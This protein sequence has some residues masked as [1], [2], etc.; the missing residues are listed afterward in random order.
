MLFFRSKEKIATWYEKHRLPRGAILS[1]G[2]TWALAKAW[3]HNRMDPDYR[4][5][6]AE[7]AQA[8]FRQVGL[9]S[10]FWS[11]AGG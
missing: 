10:S 8:V 7:Q 2:Q 6:T 4:G 5:R 9:Q 11:L 1:L 3:Y